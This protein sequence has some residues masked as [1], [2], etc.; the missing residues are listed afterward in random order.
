MQV[1]GQTNQLHLQS[2]CSEEIVQEWHQLA[3]S[4]LSRIVLK[5]K[6]PAGEGET[7]AVVGMVTSDAHVSRK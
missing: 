7:A 1:F 4:A 3:A 2:S 5:M 6:I